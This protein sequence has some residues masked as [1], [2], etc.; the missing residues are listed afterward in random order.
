MLFCAASA[1]A[2]PPEAP[3]NLRAVVLSSS[4][5]RLVWDDNGTDET[6]FEFSYTSNGGAAAT[7][8]L[9][10][11]SAGTG[12]SPYYEF[13]G[14]PTATYTFKVR[15]MKNAEASAYSNTINF[16]MGAFNWPNSLVNVTHANG[17]LTVLWT[18]DAYAADGYF[19]DYRPLPGGTWTNLGSVG[20]SSVASQGGASFYYIINRLPWMVPSASYELR[21]LG[22][23]G[24]TTNVTEYTGYTNIVSFTLPALSAPS[25]VTV[26]ATD[27][28]SVQFNIQGTNANNTGYE[29]EVSPA[30][31]N[32]FGLLGR[33]N[34]NSSA[35]YLFSV[36]ATNMVAPGM[37]YDFRVRAYYEKADTTRIYSGYSSVA[38]ATTPFHPPTNLG[39]TRSASSPYQISFTWTD[40]SSAETGYELLYRKQNL[41]NPQAF[42]S[43]KITAANAT[44]ISSL[45][46]FEPGTIYEFCV[47]ALYQYSASDVIYSGYSPIATATTLDGF[48][49]KS[50][51]PI[52]L[53]AA[54]SYQIFTQSQTARSNWSVGTLP[55]GLSFNSTT[56]VISGTVTTAG[57]YT[58]PLS[59]NFNGG[60]S[61]TQSLVLRVLNP[62]A[63]PKIVAYIPPQTLTQSGTAT[64]SLGAKFADPDTESAMRVTTSKGDL[65]LVLYST[66]TPQTVANFLSYTSAYA[67]T[68]FHRAPAGFVLQGGGYTLYSE[69]DVFAHIA[70]SA[71][72]VNEPGISN[73]VGT[74]AMAKT[75]DN[76]NSATSEFF[77][78]LGD[79]SANLDNQN[80]GF[81]VFGRLATPSL[82]GALTALQSIPTGNFNVKLYTGPTATDIVSTTFTDLPVDTDERPPSITSV[83]SLPVLTY[84]VTSA[85]DSAI[86]TATLS[87]S[88]LRINAVAPGATSITVGATDVDGNTTTQTFAINVQQTL[89]QWA[90]SQG[91]SGAQ[92]NTT[93]DPESNGLTNLEEFAFLAKPAASIPAE[94]PKLTMKAVASANYGEITFPVSKFAAGLSYAVEASNT[95]AAN[96][97]TTLWTSADGFGASAVSASEDQT[98]RTVVTVRDSQQTTVSP[99]RF[100]RVKI[101]GQ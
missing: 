26:A 62:P 88:S 18:A 100:L 93:A 6:G 76:A 32:T 79:N 17:S 86:A 27:E 40:N 9:N 72:V 89:A 46:E 74:L 35:P 38:S 80:G 92:A 19:I 8:L 94:L 41:A 44:S 47:R 34:D 25:S 69:P 58:I 99:R 39:A 85:P 13:Q 22:F 33:A 90:T 5:M 91:Y 60:T 28:T 23:K 36:P 70:T 3:T 37:A 21:V 59:A 67:N 77:V 95:L 71:P 1:L 53:G 52:T 63:A 73:L 55:A 101:T 96:D 83:T 49:S 84:T 56:G 24:T 54:F 2:I 14:V 50:Y 12:G 43:R 10:G 61:A 78:N 42:A 65:D 87:G 16:S 15:A 75:A 81:T 48:S 31:K 68:I 4:S 98:D 45:P 82:T 30:G 20:A 66:R 57:V 64:I 11:A 51:T 29:I 97:W 7:I